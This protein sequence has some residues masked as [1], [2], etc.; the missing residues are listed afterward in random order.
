VGLMKKVLITGSEGFVGKETKIL[1]KKKNI[2][3]FSYDLMLG[4]D[5]RSIDQLMSVCFEYKPNVVL[6]LAAIA[7]FSDADKDPKLAFETNVVGTK[8]VVEVCK[9]FHI[10]LV[11]ASTG[12][13]YMPITKEPPI[14]EDFPTCGNSVYGC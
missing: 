7:R 12:S 13:V 1:F 14:T 9:K 10:P 4:Y 8:N 5:I 3:N 6:H 11:Y 2:F